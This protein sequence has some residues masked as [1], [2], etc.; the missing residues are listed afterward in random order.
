[1]SDFRFYHPIEVRYGD[2]D[3]QGHLN[4]A[5]FVTYLEQA[6][7]QYMRGLG[8]WHGG[9]FLEIGI[10]LADLRLSYKAPVEF[11]AAVQV[12]VR[13]SRLGRKSLEM[14]YIINDAETGQEYATGTTIQVAYD[15][16]T[17]QSIPIP[18]V[19][20]ETIAGFEGIDQNAKTD[21]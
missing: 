12:G 1:M 18:P 3:P 19:W 10:I 2:L 17:R 8:L 7:V 11:G 21:S 4:N 14:A 20:R 5:K 13:I 9:S 15:Y 16:H 6:R